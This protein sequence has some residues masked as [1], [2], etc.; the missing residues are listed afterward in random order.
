[1]LISIY[2]NRASCWPSQTHR[3][4]NSWGITKPYQNLLMAYDR[5][6]TSANFLFLHLV[7]LESALL[8]CNW[9]QCGLLHGAKHI[10]VTRL[11]SRHVVSSKMWSESLNILED[12]ILTSLCHRA[13]LSTKPKRKR[14]KTGGQAW[15]WNRQVDFLQGILIHM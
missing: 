8:F 13:N 14:S 6:S 7:R 2:I 5:W 11:N 4:S 3:E 1:M 15:A 9:V 12:L 10:Q